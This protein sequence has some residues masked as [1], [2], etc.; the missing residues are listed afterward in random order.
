MVTHAF[1][2][3]DC[4]ERETEGKGRGGG[5]THSLDTVVEA[6]DRAL[7]LVR[8]DLVAERK[9]Q[10]DTRLLEE[11]R[12]E[13]AKVVHRVLASAGERSL[14]GSGDGSEGRIKAPSRRHPPYLNTL[15]SIHVRSS[16]GLDDHTIWT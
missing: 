5:P 8:L 4:R 7:V 6:P 2:D 3:A 16:L 13:R 14:S 9:R 1:P 12:P 15:N 10:D 11:G